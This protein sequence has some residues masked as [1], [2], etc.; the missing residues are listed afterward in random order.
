MR[1]LNLPQPVAVTLDGRGHPQSVIVGE[2]C[3]DGGTSGRQTQSVDSIVE[4]WRVDDEWW[5]EPIARLCYESVLQG[6]AHVVLYQDLVTG[7]WY[8][9]RP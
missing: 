1:P 8:M 3:L 2:P 9:Q 7:L 4:V 5:R 6:G